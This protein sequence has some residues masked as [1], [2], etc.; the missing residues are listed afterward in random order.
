MAGD[1]E[2]AKAGEDYWRLKADRPWRELSKEEKYE[3][4]MAKKRA[5]QE[6]RSSD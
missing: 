6:M 4:L 2:L 3:P 5:E 1:E